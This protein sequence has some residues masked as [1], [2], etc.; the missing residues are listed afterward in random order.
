MNII[1]CALDFVQWEAFKGGHVFIDNI[2]GESCQCRAEKVLLRSKNPGQD[3]P[4]DVVDINVT[5]LV[6]LNLTSTTVKFGS[7]ASSVLLDV[8]PLTEARSL[9]PI[10]LNL[11]P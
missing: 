8:E 7:R 10:I 6:N 5:L 2:S 4:F 3:S 9:P 1:V 11:T